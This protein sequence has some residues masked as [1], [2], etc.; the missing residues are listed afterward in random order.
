M[1]RL[2]SRINKRVTEAL[3]RYL[4]TGSGDVIRLKGHFKGESRLR[5]GDWRVRFIEY[6]DKIEILRVVHRG[7]AYEVREPLEQWQTSSAVAVGE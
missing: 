6:D 4:A 5:V 3:E 7:D 2:D 1:D